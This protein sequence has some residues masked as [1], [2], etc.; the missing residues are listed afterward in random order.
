VESINS[1][2]HWVVKVLDGPLGVLLLGYLFYAKL[3][4]A[5]GKLAE[6][7]DTTNAGFDARLEALERRHEK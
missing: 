3:V 7:V 6:I 1:A 4:A 2:W 5:I